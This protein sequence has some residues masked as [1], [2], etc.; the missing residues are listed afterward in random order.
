MTETFDAARISPVPLPGPDAV[1][2][3][4]YRGIYPMP[5]FVTV[6]TTDLAGSARFWTEGLGFIEL[7]SIPGALVHLRR[8]AFQDVLLVPGASPGPGLSLSIACVQHQQAGI[9]ER[10]QRLR[11][12]SA[13][14]P[15]PTLWN[16]IDLPVTTPEGVRVVLPAALP[17]DEEAVQRLAAVGITAPPSREA[18]PPGSRDT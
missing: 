6:P 11:P 4:P 9:A 16:T 2:P 14:D 15:Y 8:W 12:G 1:A 3:D 5:M 18:T 10:C 13:D 17:L 7:F